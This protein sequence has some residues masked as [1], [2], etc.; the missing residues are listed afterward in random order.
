L[1]RPAGSRPFFEQFPAAGQFTSHSQNKPD[2]TAGIV[3]HHSPAFVVG[4][5]NANM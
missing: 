2:G 1:K 3:E 5:G 4:A